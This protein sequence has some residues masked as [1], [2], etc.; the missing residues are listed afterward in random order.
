M[1]IKG[2]VDYFDRPALNKTALK[3]WSPYNP[4]RF[5]KRTNLNPKRKEIH[6]V[7]D[8]LAFGS[9]THCLLLEPHKFSAEFEIVEVFGLPN[10]KKTAASRNS[11][12]FR[13]HQAKHDKYLIKKT[14]YE[15]AQLMVNTL[16]KRDWIKEILHGAERE[17]PYYWNDETFLVPQGKDVIG[18]PFKAKLDA[19]KRITQGIIGIEYK[20]ATRRNIEKADW[21]EFVDY[22]MDVAMYDR[23]CWHKHGEHLHKM[24]FIVQCSDE[25]EEDFIRVITLSKDDDVQKER[26]RVCCNDLTSRTAAVTERY[27]LFQ[28]K[29]IDAWRPILREEIAE[30]RIRYSEEHE[31]LFG[32]MMYLQ[33]NQE[34]VPQASPQ[35]KRNVETLSRVLTSKKSQKMLLDYNRELE[36]NKTQ[37]AKEVYYE[38]SG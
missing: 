7:T 33:M 24:V 23:V 28:T 21:I 15:K 1:G 32:N 11:V 3:H 2:D 29:G 18:M 6:E 26:M 5:W 36:P 30:V 20:T 14:E 19:I 17:K 34:H 12:A 13:D 8:A 4:M 37:V 38:N 22:N 31:H 25:G 10:V 27:L 16:L 9:L 35:I